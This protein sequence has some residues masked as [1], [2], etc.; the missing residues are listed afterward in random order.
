MNRAIP[1]RIIQTGKSVEQ[2]LLNRAM[3]ANLRLL[4]PDF[5]Y[6]FF[7]DDQVIRFIREDFP[8]YLELF[9]SFEFPIQRFD[10]FRYLAVYRLGGFYFDLDVL[11][12]D[13]LSPLL[14]FGCVFPFE[15]LTLSTYLREERGMDWELGNYGFG[16][17]PGH[18]FLKAVI[19]ACV[20]AQQDPPS[21]DRMLKGA[22][23]L[24][25]AEYRVLNSTGPGLVSR[26]L[27]E[28]PDLAASVNVLFPEDVCDV[29]CWNRFGD[30]GVHLM[31][32]SWRLKNDFLRRKIAQR[33]EYR[34]MQTAL[35]QARTKGKHR[36]HAGNRK[37]GQTVSV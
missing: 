3:I 7:D 19:D 29:D 26:V 14:D 12:A 25:R 8:Q 27:A 36:E 15:A 37:I 31:K 30:F 28:N 13:G 16:A 6:V 1:K 21:V 4:N 5:E 17:A 33:W 35:A 10:F 18:P 2:P 34:S 22:P 24:L 20:Q 32:G 23:R 11:L 9:K